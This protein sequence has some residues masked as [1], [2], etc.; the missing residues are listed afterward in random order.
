MS[1]SDEINDIKTELR[2]G[3]ELTAELIKEIA[4]DHEINPKLL[5]R[6]LSENNITAESEMKFA[7]SLG[8][9]RD[10]SEIV[11]DVYKKCC[12]YYGV[13]DY[14]LDKRS[15]FVKDGIKYSMVCYNPQNT[16]FKH[17]LVNH[18]TGTSVKVND[19]W[20]ISATPFKMENV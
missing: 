20:L 6:K 4:E 3:V 14:P 16:K 19:R 7:S 10:M 1:L 9:A 18:K 13:H 11:E 12:K 17:I 2:K 5:E 8:K 15:I